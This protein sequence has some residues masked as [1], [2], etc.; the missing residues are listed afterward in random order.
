MLWQH[1]YK[2][3][4]NYKVKVVPKSC[5]SGILSEN[6]FFSNQSVLNAKILRRNKCQKLLL[7]Q[8]RCLW[9]ISSELQS[10]NDLL[11]K[12]NTATSTTTVSA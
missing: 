2:K 4:E 12:E 8:D 1:I 7:E 11:Q 5:Q 10:E 3:K 9:W 6:Y